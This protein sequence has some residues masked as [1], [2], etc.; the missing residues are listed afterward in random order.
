M[1]LL[2]ARRA[3]EA[4]HRR[5]QRCARHIDAASSNWGG[6]GGR[7][8]V[9]VLIR[10]PTA[11]RRADQM[12]AHADATAACLASRCSRCQ[13][14]ASPRSPRCPAAYACAYM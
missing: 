6:G 7:M 3:V 9:L 4:A 14:P 11:T 1:R 8:R 2:L 5:G 12:D 13:P 10:P